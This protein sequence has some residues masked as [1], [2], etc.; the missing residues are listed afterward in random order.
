MRDIDLSLAGHVWPHVSWSSEAPLMH[1]SSA[2]NGWGLGARGVGGWGLV[3][4]G[5]RPEQAVDYVVYMRLE[6]QKQS[7][8]ICCRIDVSF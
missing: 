7:T 1:I 2:T 5:G 4:L 6:T 8:Q 3:V